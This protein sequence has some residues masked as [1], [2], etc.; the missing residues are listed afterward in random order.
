M[1]SAVLTERMDQTFFA[2]IIYRHCQ[3]ALWFCLVTKHKSITK[4]FSMVV[5]WRELIKP[6]TVQEG[7]NTFFYC[8]RKVLNFK[9]IIAPLE[10]IIWNHI[11]GTSC[12]QTSLK[13]N[14]ARVNNNKPSINESK[15]SIKVNPACFCK[16]H[17]LPP[18]VTN[19]SYFTNKKFPK[20]TERHKTPL[21]GN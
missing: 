11:D 17:K 21:K 13:K 3:E 1:N 14:L 19:L 7:F 20:R 18:L 16:T 2:F 8:T 9:S 15:I 12:Q 4:S 5:P 10:I 6:C